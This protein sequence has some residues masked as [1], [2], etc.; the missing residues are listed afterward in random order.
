M[1]LGVCAG[2][3][4]RVFPL[5]LWSYLVRVASYGRDEG[6]RPSGQGAVGRPTASLQQVY[7]TREGLL[8]LALAVIAYCSVG[9]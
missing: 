5:L 6:H 7:V 9:R 8:S 1:D 4:L 2:T 3:V